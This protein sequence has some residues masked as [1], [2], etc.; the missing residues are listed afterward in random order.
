MLIVIECCVMDWYMWYV[1]CCHVMLCAEPLYLWWIYCR[2]NMK[3]LWPVKW[4]LSFDAT[5]SRIPVGYPKPTSNHISEF[6]WL[7]N[8]FIYESVNIDKRYGLYRLSLWLNL[9]WWC[10][11]LLC[12]TPR[13]HLYTHK[14]GLHV[15]M[16]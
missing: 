2:M 11:A 4:H 10:C 7:I 5:G 15:G 13:P 9:W 3:T 14:Y 12:W 1:M 16:G 8:Y 6:L